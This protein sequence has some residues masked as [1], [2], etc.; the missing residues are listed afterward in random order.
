MTGPSRH[1]DCEQLKQ[2]L[3]GSA[4][5]GLLQ[6]LQQKHLFLG[7]FRDWMQVIVKGGVKL[8]H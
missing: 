5:H 4:Y 7:C 6:K 8:D 1:C 3:N 2:E